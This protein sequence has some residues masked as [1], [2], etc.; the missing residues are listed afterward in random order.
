[1]TPG[2]AGPGGEGAPATGRSDLALRL[3]VAGIGIPVG[4]AVVWT[5]GL[6]LALVILVVALLGVDE[7]Y[8]MARRKGLAPARLLGMAGVVV[9]LAAVSADPRIEVL[10]VWGWAMVMAVTLLSLSRVIW[11]PGPAGPAMTS[12]SVTLAGMIYGGGTLAFALL[13]RTLPPGVG[14][15]PLGLRWEGAFVLMFPL[16]VTWMGD[17]AAYFT[18]RRFGRRKLIPAVSPK[19][20]VEGAL[21]GLAGAVATAALLHLLV[22]R[23]IPGFDLSFT[24]ILLTGVLLGISAQV[25]DLAESV[26]KREA[27]VKDSGS[28]LPGHGGILDRFD[29]ILFNVPLCWFLFEIG[30]R[31]P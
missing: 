25:G 30:V 27:G 15:G 12:A 29:A 4:V 22:L 5:G 26:L 8:A 14:G 13:L 24:W 6:L 1:V 3:M 28:L 16:I 11:D 17:S 31:L 20:T 23:T 2:E 21:G 10:A 9:L 7:F 19:K 18:G